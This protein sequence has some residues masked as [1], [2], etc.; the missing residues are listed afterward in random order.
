MAE[1]L[2]RIKARALIMPSASDRLIPPS[3]AQDLQ[4]GMKF[5]KYIEIPSI[6]G[7]LAYFPPNDSDPEFAF[8]SKHIS[9]FLETLGQ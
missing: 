4:K 2:A 3:A 1:A 6:L 8:V 5:A 9:E 7:H